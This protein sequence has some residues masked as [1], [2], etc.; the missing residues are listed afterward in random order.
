MLPEQEAF[1]CVFH[2][3]LDCSTSSVRIA[4]QALLPLEYSESGKAVYFKSRWHIETTLDHL[5]LKFCKLRYHMI[6]NEDMHKGVYR[7]HINK[8]GKKITTKCAKRR[9]SIR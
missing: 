9:L 1:V 6:E 7:V 5:Q 8:Q 2:D 4:V 3:K